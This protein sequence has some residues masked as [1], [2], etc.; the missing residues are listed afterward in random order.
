MDAEIDE[1]AIPALAAPPRQVANYLGGLRAVLAE[2]VESRRSWTRELGK[3]AD[4]ARQQQR[5]L[6]AQQAGRVGHRQG[7]AFRGL[8][9]RLN[10]LSPP[11]GCLI[12]HRAVV[13]WLDI[14]LAA[15][16]VMVEVGTS[17]EPAELRRVQ[18]VLADGREQARRFNTEYRQILDSLREAVRVGTL[19]RRERERERRRRAAERARRI[20]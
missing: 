20:R 12:C 9:A 4:D 13:S 18:R 6:V 16:D 17:G 5:V 3:L 11:P 10:Q 15:C 7:E 19:R 1:G 14:Q 8:R 2:A